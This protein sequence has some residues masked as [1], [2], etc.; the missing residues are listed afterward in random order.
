MDKMKTA[1]DEAVRDHP[2]SFRLFYHLLCVCYGHSSRKYHT[3]A[4]LEHCYQE[5]DNY[6][7]DVRKQ[8]SLAVDLSIPCHD[9]IYDPFSTTN[10]DDSRNLI[11][12]IFKVFGVSE[13][14]IKQV[15]GIIWVTSTYADDY[16]ICSDTLSLDQQ[17][18]H[19]LDLSGFG[20]SWREFWK[21]SELVNQEFSMVPSDE[22]RTKRLAFLRKLSQRDYLFRTDYFREKYETRAKEN[23]NKYIEELRLRWL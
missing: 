18:M 5:Y 15:D 20:L 16:P 4:H 17:L 2:D 23:I 12:Y 10:E 8:R 6:L 9:L 11:K 22:F 14:L 21:Q 19:D 13:T 1:W 3:F 7:Y